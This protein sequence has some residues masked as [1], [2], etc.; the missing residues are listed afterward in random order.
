LKYAFQNPE[1]LFIV[2]DY[3]NGG[4]LF[5][6]LQQEDAFSEVRA[7][8][9]A[10]EIVLALGYLHDNGIIYRD[11]KPE[12][13]LLD[14][15]G[16]ICL[17]DFGLCKTGIG[18]TEKTSTFCGSLEYMAPELL[19]GQSYQNDIDWWALA[20][21]VYEMIEGIPPFWDEQPKVMLEQISACDLNAKFDDKFSSECIG[22][23]TSILKLDANNRLGRGLHGTE[24][25]K[26]HPWFSDIDWVRLYNKQLE[27]PFKPHL[28]D[29][30]DTRYFDTEV[31]SE[32]PNVPLVNKKFSQM[33]LQDDPFEDFSF[34][35]PYLR[36]SPSKSASR[37]DQIRTKGARRSTPVKIA[38]KRPTVPT[39]PRLLEILRV[40]AK[41]SQVLCS[42]IPKI[43][44]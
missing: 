13:I 23:I 5:F 8:F 40:H 25:I 19:S 20:T 26:N 31:T 44:N 32:D 9:Y 11:L 7:K 15:E 39:K 30:S 4:E 2:I 16:H 6:H 41:S 29:A 3:L 17:V 33:T 34:E 18:L 1:Y 35:D 14:M 36:A 38:K 21:M 12:N 27:P 10:A 42:L 24:D 37:Q 43:R 28:K 22:F